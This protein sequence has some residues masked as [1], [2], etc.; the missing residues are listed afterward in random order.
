MTGS[1][2]AWWGMSFGMHGEDYD[3][4]ERQPLKK[5]RSDAKEDAGEY[6]QHGKLLG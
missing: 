3:E 5:E 4:Q 6:A 2:N 1:N